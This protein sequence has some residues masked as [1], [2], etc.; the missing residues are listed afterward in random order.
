MRAVYLVPAGVVLVALGAIG[1]AAQ[2]G[3]PAA[4]P[5]PA[6]SPAA[7][8]QVPVTAAARAC[9]PA[10]GGAAAPVA[11]LAGGAAVGGAG[12]TAQN[13]GQGQGQV[14]LTALPPA[15]VPVHAAAAVRA[16]SPGAL[17]VLTLPAAKATG[18]QATTQAAQGWSVAGGGAMAQGL[19]AELT[20]D[21]GLA[22]VRC[23]APGSDL[24]FIGP[25]QQNG[26]SQVQVD[27]MNVDSTA[28]SVDVSVINDG[29]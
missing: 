17:S 21:S 16:Q 6:S 23:A 14:E 24:W 8:R 19:E 10:P 7:I 5:R 22:S 20:Q 28:A 13:Q 2:L 9:P 12:A 1:G 25:G 27:L 29:G 26:G 15:G 18:K 11:L 3:H 4:T